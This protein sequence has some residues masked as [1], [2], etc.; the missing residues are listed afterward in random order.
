MARTSRTQF[1][2]S[3]PPAA[4]Q[5]RSE[6]TPA[7]IPRSG[8]CASAERTPFPDGA[9]VRSGLFTDVC[10]AVCCRCGRAEQPAVGSPQRGLRLTASWLAAWFN[11]STGVH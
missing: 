11:M 10:F 1:Y 6:T 5:T 4:V 3:R 9:G 8:S 7:G 2:I